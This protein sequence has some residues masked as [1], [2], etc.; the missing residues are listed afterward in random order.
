[1][2]PDLR[3]LA[4]RL[5]SEMDD[6]GQYPEEAV[7]DWNFASDIY[8]ALRSAADQLDAQK[9]EIERLIVACREHKSQNDAHQCVIQDLEQRVF[10]LRQ[11]L[12]LKVST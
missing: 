10:R 1:M 4:D 6:M 5:G 7:L 11:T 2:T 8:S 3:A 12:A 9:A